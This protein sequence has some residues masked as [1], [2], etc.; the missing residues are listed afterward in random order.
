MT[1]APPPAAR[2]GF[3]LDPA[4]LVRAAFGYHREGDLEAAAACC[5][6]ALAQA[7][8]NFEAL[9]LLGMLRVTQGRA[10][11]GIFLL[12]R[13]AGAAPGQD[14][15]WYN[16]GVALSGQQRHEE[17]MRCYRRALECNPQD[18]DRLN[19]L[20]IIFGDAER[21]AEA[22]DC[23]RRATLLQADYADAHG[24]LGTA[25]QRLGRT[26]EA[27]AS[28]RHALALR[29][30]EAVAHYR[31]G[32]VLGEQNKLEEAI[33][34]YRAS[35]ALRPD[36]HRTRFNLALLLLRGG[37]FASGLAEYECRW[38]TGVLTP[39]PHAAGRPQWRGEKL[40][41]GTMVLLHAEQGFGDTLQMARYA[42]LLAA[43]GVTV[44]LEVQPALKRLLA[45]VPGVFAQGE[46]LPPFDLQCPMMSLPLAFAT[47]IETIPAPLP[48]AAASRRVDDVLRVGIAWSGSPDNPHDRSRTVPLAV[49]R[50]ILDTPG[51]RFHLLQPELRAADEAAFAELS[52]VVDYRGKIADFADTA[53]IIGEMDLVITTDTAVAHLAGTMAR[54][55]WLLLPFAP[56][57]R[58][59]LGRD[60]SPWYPT[61]R[62]FR[63]D[64]PGDWDGVIDRVRA[65]L[66]RFG[67]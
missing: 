21:L 33:A 51:C 26:E 35:L 66:G 63:Q 14:V 34:C 29:P 37:D 38:Q 54:P 12:R 32:V 17:A 4:T 9:H 46:A 39:S 36:Q 18:A 64:R 13:A 3:R 43:R 62:L 27:T 2:N 10:E 22:E 67:R 49:F 16:L 31:L 47:T 5:E 65:E 52:N 42:P 23:F 11:D 19:R 53:A 7:P 41:P 6:T 40:P 28:F 55:V 25:L 24:N 15:V 48:L 44:L 59:L 58:W 57:W 8:N 45:G 1:D 61:A 56:D 60:D 30:D 50:R 20:G